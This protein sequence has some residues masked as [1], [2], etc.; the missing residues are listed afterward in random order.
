[1]S[2]NFLHHD[3]SVI[4]LGF[5]GMIFLVSCLSGTRVYVGMRVLEELMISCMWCLLLPKG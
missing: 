4:N 1:M 5:K 2:A 3:I